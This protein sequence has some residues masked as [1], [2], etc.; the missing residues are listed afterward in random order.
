[1]ERLLIFSGFLLIA[2][3]SYANANTLTQT[4]I[5][6]G[7]ECVAVSLYTIEGKELNSIVKNKRTIEKT[8]FIPEGWTVVGVTTK[9]ENDISNP[10][11]VICH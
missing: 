9:N 6:H 3:N 1:M 11:L 7:Q 4:D 5:K 8:N 10:Y 2:C